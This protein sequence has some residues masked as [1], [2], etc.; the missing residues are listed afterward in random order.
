MIRRALLAAFFLCFT[1]SAVRAADQTVLGTSFIVRNPSTAVKQKISA[2][3]KEKVSD[4]TIVGDP[5]TNG[6]TVVISANGGNSTEQ[7]FTLPA[8]NDP[9]TS[10]PFWSGDAIKGYKYSDPKGANGALKSAQIK[11]R[12]GVFQ[13]KVAVD[14]KLGPVLVVPPAFGTDGCVLL[15]IGGGDSYSVEFASGDVTNDGAVLFKV[16]KPTEQGSCVTTTT[17]TPTTSSSTTTLAIPFRTPPGAAPLRYRDQIFATVDVTS[18]VTYGSAVNNSGQTVTLLL[19]IYEP[20]GDA[21]TARPAIVWVHGGSFAFGSK[22][23][24]ELVEQANLFARKGYFNVSINY[25][26]EPPGCSAGGVTALC[27]IA[28][29]EAMQDAQTAVR[30][31]RTNAATYGIDVDRIAMGGSSAG[32]ITALNVGFRSA[33]DPSA[34][35]AGAVSLSGANILSVIGAGD[36]PSLLFHGTSDGVVPY[37]WAVNTFNSATAAGLDTFLTSWTGAGHVPYVAHKTEIFDQTQNFLYWEMDLANA[38][39]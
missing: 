11:L 24:P 26:L 32:A 5:V 4:N 27:I 16:N 2:K 3:A 37:Q 17:T 25:R 38:A 39:Q 20:T 36:A 31:L 23:S 7:T 28:I 14:G 12:N 1:T 29:T 21:I 18:N 13:M 30:Y 35:I 34:A 6:A 33:E 8:G 15:T 10:R 9:V 19:D 22:T